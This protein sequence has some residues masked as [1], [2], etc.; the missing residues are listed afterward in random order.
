VLSRTSGEAGRSPAGHSRCRR[1]SY[2]EE[3]DFL[4][5]VS[6]VVDF[7]D[8]CCCLWLFSSPRDAN[9]PF[10][11]EGAFA[12]EAR[13]WIIRTSID[14]SDPPFF[15]S[16]NATKSFLLSFFLYLFRRAFPQ[17]MLP[18]DHSGEQFSTDSCVYF[19][20]RVEGMN[21]CLL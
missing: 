1:W 12:L 6:P 19:V 21:V 11:E 10:S 16:D 14:C 7:V 8:S 15:L 5:A 18:L 4:V 2:L 17:P 3:L 9:V 20:Q 13:G